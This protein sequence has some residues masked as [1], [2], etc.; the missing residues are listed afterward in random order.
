MSDNNYLQAIPIRWGMSEYGLR[1]FIRRYVEFHERS[2]KENGGN[3]TG[4]TADAEP[5]SKNAP[6]PARTPNTA[7]ATK[8][9]KT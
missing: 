2:M 6:L 1:E 8:S 5:L 4:I 3:P 9:V 7:K